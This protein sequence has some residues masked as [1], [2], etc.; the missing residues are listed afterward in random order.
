MPIGVLILKHIYIDYGT[1]LLYEMKKL[2]DGYTPYTG[3]TSNGYD[4]CFVFVYVCAL[5][6]G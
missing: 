6:L 2:V 3:S 5:S 1:Q 4:K